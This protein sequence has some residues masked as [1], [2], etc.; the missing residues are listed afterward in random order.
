MEA[1]KPESLLRRCDNSQ[2]DKL[3]VILEGCRRILKHL[4]RKLKKYSA[5]DNNRNRLGKKIWQQFWFRTKEVPALDRIRQ[6]LATC[7]QHLQLFINL[8]V[9]ELQGK[10]EQYLEKQGA[11]LTNI[12][13]VLNRLVAAEMVGQRETSEFTTPTNDEKSVWRDFR[14]GLIDEGIG[15]KTIKGTKT[16]SCLILESWG[17]VACWTKYRNIWIMYRKI[18]LKVFMFTLI[19]AR[20]QPLVFNRV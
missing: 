3:N 8:L 5:L 16:L 11:D 17:R 6:Q 14:R 4:E 10:V 12:R 9:Y 1:E 2:V 7:T 15:S 18:S 13:K 20:E 19:L